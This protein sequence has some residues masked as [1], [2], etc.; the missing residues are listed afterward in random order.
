V[1]KVVVDKGKKPENVQ[2]PSSKAWQ[3]KD[4]PLGIGSSKVFEPPIVKAIAK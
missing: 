3:P 4:N 2:K 1:E